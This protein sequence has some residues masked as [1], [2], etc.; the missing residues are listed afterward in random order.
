MTVRC[1]PAKPDPDPFRTWVQPFAGEHHAGFDQLFVIPSHLGEEF[2]TREDAGL[3]GLGGFD[4]D[5]ESHFCIL[6][7][8]LV[9]RSRSAIRRGVL[10]HHDSFS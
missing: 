9:N 10:R 2:L 3:R 7:L 8:F 1:S 5:H 6:V 4:Y